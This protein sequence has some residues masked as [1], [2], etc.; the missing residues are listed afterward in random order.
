MNI[1]V[2]SNDFSN[3]TGEGRLARNFIFLIKKKYPSYTITINTPY[4]KLLLKRSKKKKIDAIY[5]NNFFYK[6]FFFIYGI[7]YLWLN[8]KNKIVYVNYL[9]LW[10]FLIF[11]LL[12]KKTILGPITGGVNINEIKNIEDFIR[13]FFFPIFYKISLFIIRIKFRRAI[14]STNLLKKN[15]IN[16]NNFYFGYVY[17]FFTDKYFFCNKKKKY[18]LIFYNRTYPSKKNYLI[19]KIILELSTKIKI[20]VVG[21]RY[22]GTSFINK[23]YI[24]HKKILEL[25][26]QS[27]MAFATSENLLSLFAIDCYNSGV[28]LIYD[29]KTL[30]DNIISHQNSLG[31]DY[32]DYSNSAKLIIHALNRYK[33]KKDNKFI[34]YVKKKKDGF[35]IFFREYLKK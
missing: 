5:K 20:C 10:N 6:Y 12:P 15:I 14:F 32:H 22:E 30:T 21:N 26:S 18:D 11:L 1:F 13:I 24:P 34:N 19:K 2:W 9:P 3:N 4:G 25:I 35:K 27:K 29:K 16:K 23:G 7:F 28:K 8:K 31:I 33:F 17:S